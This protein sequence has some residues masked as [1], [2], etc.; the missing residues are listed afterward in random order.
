MMVC[1]FF[2]HRDCYGLEP[3]MLQHT[4]EEVIKKEKK[5]AKGHLS[6]DAE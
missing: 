2:G 6:D 4:I 5:D 3:M 1:T